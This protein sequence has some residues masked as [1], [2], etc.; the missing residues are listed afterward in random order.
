MTLILFCEA[1][2][3]TVRISASDAYSFWWFCETHYLPTVVDLD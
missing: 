2:G 3:T 1:C